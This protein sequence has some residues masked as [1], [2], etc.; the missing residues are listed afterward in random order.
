VVLAN[1]NH[2]HHA[3]MPQICCRLFLPIHKS[4]KLW[5][6]SCACTGFYYKHYQLASNVIG[7]TAIGTQRSAV[8]TLKQTYERQ[9]FPELDI[10]RW[11]L[12]LHRLLSSLPGAAA[13]A[14]AAVAA[15][16][17][18]HTFAFSCPSKL[19]D[20]QCG[21][22]WDRMS[23]CLPH[24]L[25]AGRAILAGFHTW[26]NTECRNSGFCLLCLISCTFGSSD[27]K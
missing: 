7:S 19:C 4:S 13:A 20:R 18:L 1:P 21:A 23:I 26:S 9:I 27:L 12:N 10:A 17:A 24:K 11:S 15:A 6:C 22:A 3:H 2:L 25:T 5:T 16:P 8:S 14:A